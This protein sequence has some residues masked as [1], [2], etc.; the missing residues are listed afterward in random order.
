MELSANVSFKDTLQQAADAPARVSVHMR[1]GQTFAGKVAG[2]GDHHVVL[3][4][5]AEREF[6]DA[7]LRIEDISAIE[8]RARGR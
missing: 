3:A 4:E 6:Y 8:V 2:V 7:V 5:L 1:S